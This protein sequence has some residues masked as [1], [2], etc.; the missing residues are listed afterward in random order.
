MSDIRLLRRI[1]LTGVAP[2]L[3]HDLKNFLQGL[4]E[5]RQIHGDTSA[6]FGREAVILGWRLGVRSRAL[7]DQDE[8]AKTVRG[9]DFVGVD[10][11]LKP[12][13]VQGSLSKGAS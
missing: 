5:V 10:E 2:V 9:R 4:I 13:R 7:C 6:P 8:Q 12:P 1:L 3:P 11:A